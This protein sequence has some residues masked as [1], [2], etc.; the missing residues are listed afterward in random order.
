MEE[1]LSAIRREFA[2]ELDKRLDL[3]NKIQELQDEITQ[4]KRTLIAIRSNCNMTNRLCKTCNWRDECVS[5][6]HVEGKTQIC[7]SFSQEEN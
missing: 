1:H 5:A 4:V 2:E 7:S 6:F 3:L